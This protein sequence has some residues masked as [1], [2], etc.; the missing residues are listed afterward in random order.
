MTIP[1]S[2]QLFPFFFQYFFFFRVFC[3]F[4]F[5]IYYFTSNILINKIILH[6]I[7]VGIYYKRMTRTILVSKKPLPIHCSLFRNRYIGKFLIQIE[8]Y[9]HLW[10]INI[11]DIYNGFVSIVFFTLTLKTN[12]YNY[13][14]YCIFFIGFCLWILL[15]FNY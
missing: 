15:I 1:K 5:I 13:S 14:N 11:V 2:F 3:C 6:G 4:Y 8:E 7:I 10:N 9:F 12:Q